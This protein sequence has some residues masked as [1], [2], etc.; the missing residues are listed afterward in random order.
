MKKKIVLALVVLMFTAPAFAAVTIS[1]VDEGGGIVA[2]KYSVSGEASRVRAFALEL[3]VDQ[4]AILNITDFNVG[5]CNS[6]KKGYGIFMG[7]IKIDEQGDVTDY[8]N[9]VAPL[10]APDDPCQLG[11]DKITVEMGSLYEDSNFPADNG[12]LFKIKV[13]I[14]C[15]VSVDTNVLRGGVILENGKGSE[16]VASP[17]A[18]VAPGK[19]ATPA[20]QVT[21]ARC[22]TMGDVDGDNYVCPGDMAALVQYIQKNSNAF[23]KFWCVY[24]EDPNF[25]DCYD[26]D[27]DG[28]VCPGDISAIVAYL[29]ANTNAFPNFW[30]ILDLPFCDPDW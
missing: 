22:P 9:P 12:T 11:S 28:Y 2:I 13:C 14:D 29:Q 6:L 26:V 30:C 21:S 7:S 3:S 27:E 17:L 24:P 10:D 19:D 20:F 8:N 23:P 15:N 4:G 18:V 5:E 25:N 16:D 1:C